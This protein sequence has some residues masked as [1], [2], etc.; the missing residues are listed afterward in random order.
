ME[1]V[2]SAGAVLREQPA[3]GDHHKIAMLAEEKRAA[4]IAF[5][6]MNRDTLELG[7]L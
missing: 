6:L 7:A 1:T 2:T 5:L 4:H 3:V